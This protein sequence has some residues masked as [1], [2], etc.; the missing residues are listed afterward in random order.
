ME[1][2]PD[3]C[4]ATIYVQYSSA[5]YSG[6]QAAYDNARSAWNSRPANLLLYKGSSQ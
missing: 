5:F 3:G 4:C 6:D 2:D 1:R